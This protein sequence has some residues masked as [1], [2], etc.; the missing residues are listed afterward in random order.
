MRRP[1]FALAGLGAGLALGVWSVRAVQ[2]ARRR[3][4]PDQLAQSAAARAGDWRGRL[5]LA[6]EQGRAAAAAR[7]S[8][9]RDVY[10]VREPLEPAE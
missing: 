4:T 1:F 10:R 8:E 3:L 2:D 9:L 6:V 5:A 7:E